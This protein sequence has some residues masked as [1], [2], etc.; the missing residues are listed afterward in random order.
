MGD[1][2][3]D[4]SYPNTPKL[5]FPFKQWKVNSYKF[6]ERCFYDGKDWGLHLGE[7]CNVKAGTAVHAIG[8][9]RVVYSALH[10][11]KNSPKKGGYRNWGNIIVIAH[12][13]P[14]TKKVFYSLYAHLKNRL[15]QRGDPVTLGDW[16]EDLIPDDY[17]SLELTIAPPIK[18]PGVADRLEIS[19][20]AVAFDE[21]GVVYLRAK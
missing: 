4:M 18:L 21:V 17:D 10:A 14:K 6:K 2:K 12:K 19:Y 15:V 13:N 11:T 1:L 16:D 5:E 8:R 9:G 7:D 20:G 3:N